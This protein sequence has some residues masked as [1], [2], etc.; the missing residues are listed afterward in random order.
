M[1]LSEQIGWDG[2]GSPLRRHKSQPI[3]ELLVL[4]SSSRTTR[5]A[6]CEPATATLS[7]AHC[8][9]SPLRSAGSAGHGDTGA[10]AL[11]PPPPAATAARRRRRR[12]RR[13]VS[14]SARGGCALILFCRRMLCLLWLLASPDVA[15]FGC[16]RGSS[17]RSGVTPPAA[18][19]E[20]T[21]RGS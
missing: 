10:G 12:R 18:A 5:Q 9:A 17:A 7:S 3:A 1:E 14:P 19:A 13:V 2:G 21:A 20:E 16:A 15:G 4:N 8:S 11:P 6:G